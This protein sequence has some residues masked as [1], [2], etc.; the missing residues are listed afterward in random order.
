MK[1]HKI[2]H[3]LA[4]TLVTLIALLGTPASAN[5]LKKCY[6]ETLELLMTQ[7]SRDKP[8]KALGVISLPSPELWRVEG[9]LGIIDSGDSQ[10]VPHCLDEPVPAYRADISGMLGKFSRATA[11]ASTDI[12]N[13]VSLSLSFGN[14]YAFGEEL[15]RDGRRKPKE[16]PEIPYGFLR[17]DWDGKNSSEEYWQYSDREFVAGF[18][19][20]FPDTVTDPMGVPIFVSCGSF[21]YCKIEYRLLEALIIKYSFLNVKNYQDVWIKQDQAMRDLVNGWITD[22]HPPD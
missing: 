2:N 10:S 17:K 15:F 9:P 4:G 8:D 6:G 11:D 14:Y 5:A 20:A 3:R 19:F 21:G 7:A 18:L 22:L 16:W 1:G 12:E 13:V